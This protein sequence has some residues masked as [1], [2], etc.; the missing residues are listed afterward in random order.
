MNGSQRVGFGFNP[1]T[2]SLGAKVDIKAQGALSTD[3]AFRVRNSANTA[4][5]IEQRGNGSLLFSNLTST[6]VLNPRT[7]ADGFSLS[8]G[9]GLYGTGTGMEVVSNQFVINNSST[10]TFRFTGSS[11][12]NL[13][14]FRNESGQLRIAP[15]ADTTQPT[16]NLNNTNVIVGGLSVG[17]S[18]TKTFAIYSGT[19]PSTSPVDAFQQYSADIV[20]GNAAPHFRTENGNIIKLYRQSSAGI[21]TVADLVTVL[22]NLGLLA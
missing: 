14:E 2:D 17:T 8:S 5:L 18:A 21:T 15:T 4:N 1:L 9:S 20:A 7:D 19:A 3:I 10:R 11:V 12:T 22:T 6:Y 16:L 13:W